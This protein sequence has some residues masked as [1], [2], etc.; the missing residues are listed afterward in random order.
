MK[1]N[2]GLFW[3]GIDKDI[4]EYLDE[5]SKPKTYGTLMELRAIAYMYRWVILFRSLTLPIAIF[6]S[7]RNVILFEAYNTGT[8]LIKE[9]H[10]EQVFRVFFTP[11]RHFDTVFTS[12]FIETAAFCQGRLINKVM[13]YSRLFNFF[14]VNRGLLRNTL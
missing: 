1:S 9:N 10:F 11:E 13:H 3:K 6:I 8:H 4:D 7:R 14:F 2:M 12:G 5:M